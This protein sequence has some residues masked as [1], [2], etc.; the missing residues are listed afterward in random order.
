MDASNRYGED[1]Y[2]FGDFD[3]AS[4]QVCCFKCHKIGHTDATHNKRK[5]SKKLETRNGS[6]S[7]LKVRKVHRLK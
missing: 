2:G 6:T 3:E 4:G 5:K 1:M 7:G